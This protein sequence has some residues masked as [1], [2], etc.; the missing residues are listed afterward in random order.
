LLG[1]F[2]VE[3]IVKGLKK[4]Y[5]DHTVLDNINMEF[6]K[7]G[8]YLIAGPNGSGKTTLLEIIIGLRK[9]T[10]GEVCI[11]NHHPDSLESKRSLGFL[12]QQNSLRKSCYVNEEMELV[13]E[14]FE[15]KCIDIKE[16]LEKYDL[17][18]YYHQRIRKLSGGTKRRLLLAMTFLPQQDIIL[19]DEPVSGLDSFSRNEIWNMITEVAQDKIIILSDHYLNQA[20]QYSDYVYLLDEGRIVLQGGLKQV[21][22]SLKKTHVLKVRKGKHSEIENRLKSLGFE[23]DLKVSGTVYSYYFNDNNNTSVSSIGVGDFK[24]SNI[25]FEDIYFYYTGKYIHERS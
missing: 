12:S 3:V 11:G 8:I 2:Y 24:I 21:I 19:L 16:Y 1:G 5:E 25:D 20:A 6:K 9:Q 7:P 23:I 4:C 10:E 14:I 17:A 15:L 22:S 18:Q 13:A